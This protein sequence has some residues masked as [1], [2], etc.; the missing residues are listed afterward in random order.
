MKKIIGDF[1]AK[2]KEKFVILEDI[3]FFTDNPEEKENV[4]NNKKYL[5]RRKAIMIADEECNLRKSIYKEYKRN[6]YKCGLI[7]IN[8]Y[9]ATL[10]K[11]DERYAW[12]IKVI[13]GKCGFKEEDKYYIGNFDSN[14]IKVSCLVFV[15]NGEYVYLGYEFDTR[16]IRMVT[17]DEF[18]TYINLIKK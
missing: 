2:V 1:I 8:D 16:K 10:V 3:I 15:D 4:L 5:S 18:L 11:Y 12:Y 6:G 7:E 17:D 9:Y 13:D 14:N